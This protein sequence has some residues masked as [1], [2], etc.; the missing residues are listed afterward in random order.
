MRVR[1]W[2]EITAQP[3]ERCR[4]EGALP[5]FVVEFQ[6]SRQE[7]SEQAHR[8]SYKRQEFHQRAAYTI[9]REIGE[10]VR[11]MGVYGMVG[12]SKTFNNSSV[13]G[14]KNG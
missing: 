9:R 6:G 8:L 14:R 4:I 13:G 1:V 12:G 10:K 7:L 3:G 5:G 2:S 11:N